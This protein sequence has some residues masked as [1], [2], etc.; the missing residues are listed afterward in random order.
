[1]FFIAT[2]YSHFGAIQ[3]KRRAVG[4]RNP[5][6]M[7]VPRRL[8]SSCGTCVR[9]EAEADFNFIAKPWL[10]VEQVVYKAPEGYMCI[11]RAQDS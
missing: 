6:L 4:I 1:M 11:Y 8:S 10:D 7:P 3:F 5:Q 9:F 2:F